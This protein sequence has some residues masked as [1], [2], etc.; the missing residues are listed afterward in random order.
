V[1]AVCAFVAL[2]LEACV[3]LSYPVSVPSVWWTRHNC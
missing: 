2:W 1:Y 3:I